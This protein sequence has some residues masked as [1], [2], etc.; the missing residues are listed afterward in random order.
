M[1]FTEHYTKRAERLPRALPEHVMAQLEHPDNLARFDDPALQ[2]PSENPSD[3]RTQANLRLEKRAERLNRQ[4]RG[5][6]TE[7]VLRAK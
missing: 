6:Q 3:V 2:N 4:G 1:F 7:F 5:D